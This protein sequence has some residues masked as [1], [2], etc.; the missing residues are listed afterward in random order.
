MCFL[1]NEI[2]VEEKKYADQI[3]QLRYNNNLNEA[4]SLCDE[5]I[6]KFR[7]NNFFYKIKGDILFTIEKYP[8]AMHCYLEYLTCI[9]Q[10][11]EFFTNF[12]R[13]FVKIRNYYCVDKSVFQR[14]LVLSRDATYSD[15]IRKGLLK[16]I[17]DYWPE[18]DEVKDLI[19]YVN[20]HYSSAAINDAFSALKGKDE[21]EKIYFLAKLDDKNC[22][23]ENISVNKQVI[24]AMENAQ[25]YEYALGWVL[26]MLKYSKDR[27]LVRSLF[28]I[29]RLRNDYSDAIN[30][31]QE[32]DITKLEDFNVQYELV[33]FYNAQ[34][35]E[36]KRNQTLNR[37]D[38]K[39]PES[40]PI[41][42]TLFKFYVEYDMI[43]NARAV[44]KR[45]DD[46]KLRKNI[47]EKKR[48]AIEKTARENQDLM[49]NRLND[50]VKEQ[51]HNRQMLAITE[52]IKGFSHELG[53]PI[54]NIRYAI[55]LFYMK[56]EKEHTEIS[57]ESKDLLDG[58]LIQT[59]R[60]GK[61]LGRFAPIVSSKNV[62][63]MFCVYD[64]IVSIFEELEIRLNSEGIKYSVS[65]DRSAK[66]FGETIQ[67]SQIFYNLI[68]N[69]I[70]AI[71][72]SGNDGE[73]DVEIKQEKS[74]LIIRFRD[75]GIG[76]P[77]EIQRKIFDPFFST[78]RKEVEE[79]GEG[80][81]LYI[82]WNILKMFNGKIYVDPK[83]RKGAMFVM[84]IKKEE[85][86][87]V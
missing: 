23:K 11:P 75:N 63:I 17:C 8:Q 20:S 10:K 77:D 18:S 70:Y 42:K 30:F 54:T 48:K 86:E 53:Q 85:K 1:V 39:Y 44:E 4:I 43:E 78:K 22:T 21:C 60:V 52:L 19:I 57:E 45:I 5:A 25:M 74:L 68:I 59:D 49:W 38:T 26:H 87:N 67:F 41:A 27:V 82:V 37:I 7:S 24:K 80:L 83:Y 47:D 69:S 73:I 66:L 40:I 62:K 79:G 16:I 81:G 13:F 51:E 3:F 36:E 64:E 46:L 6:E 14:M 56:K 34:E 58:I 84:E 61:L 33:L 71:N 2:S 76:I 35:D 55:Q 32:H 12:S 9:R 72:K 28:R 15:V 31:M 50:L 65:G 29:C